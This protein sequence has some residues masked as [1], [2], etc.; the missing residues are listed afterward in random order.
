M[1]SGTPS[2]LLAIIRL[3][4]ALHPSILLAVSGG[5][6]CGGKNG[7]LVGTT[8]ENHTGFILINH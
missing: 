3:D 8:A 4:S 5:I 1:G 7:I 2:R 6:I